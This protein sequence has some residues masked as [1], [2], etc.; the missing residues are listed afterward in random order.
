[1]AASET[2]KSVT[3][4]RKEAKSESLVISQPTTT[5]A[6]STKVNASQTLGEKVQGE[7]IQPADDASR[8]VEIKAAAGILPPNLF[9]PSTGATLPQGSRAI[10]HFEWTPVEKASQYELNVSGPDA[11]VPLINVKIEEPKYD[12]A[13]GSGIIYEQNSRNWVWK[14]R[15]KDAAG[16]WGGWSVSSRFDVEKPTFD[17]PIEAAVRA[18]DG[19]LPPDLLAPSTAETLSQGSRAIWHFEWTPVENATQY[20][21][22]VSGP[23]AQFPLINVKTEKPKYDHKFG[24]GYIAQQNKLNWTWKVRAKDAFGVWG[25]WSVTRVFDVK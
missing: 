12:Y 7:N 24:R 10:W 22:S 1:V 18:A 19:P 4:P 2:S 16:V 14:V 8:E 13:F 25:D 9:K 21:L 17:A 11:A 5:S 23:N 6:D 20:E 3:E 15:A